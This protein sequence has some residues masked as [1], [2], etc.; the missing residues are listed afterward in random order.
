MDL[1]RNVVF[2]SAQKIVV[3]VP[4]RWGDM[5]A[6]RHVNNVEVV[7]LL[8]EARVR[9]FGPPAHT[10]LPGVQV[11][12]AVFSDVPEGVQSLVVE[13]QVKYISPL[14]YRNVPCT[15]EVW[16]SAIKGAS[17]ALSYQIFDGVDGGLCVKARTTLAFFDEGTGRLTRVSP[18]HRSTLERY[19][20]VSS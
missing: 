1:T 3:Q 17:I 18:E 13:H 16:V 8:E 2:V 4:L 20:I 14:N 12:H 6:Y 10:G 11:E 5:D 7:R 9:A 19:L 15:V